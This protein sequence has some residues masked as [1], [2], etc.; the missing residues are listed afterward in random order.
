MKTNFLFQCYATTAVFISSLAGIMAGVTKYDVF[1]SIFTIGGIFIM[2]G[3]SIFDQKIKYSAGRITW[4]IVSSLV[5]CFL[6]KILYDEK[7]IS[8]M[9]M[10]VA[11]LISSMIAPAVLSVIL[12]DLPSRVSEQ[13]LK[14]PEILVVALKNKLGSKTNTDKDEQ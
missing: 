5:S 1:W 6:I 2:I 4:M 14:L 8:L 12:R 7:I 11:T 3:H 9:S 13:I 10:I